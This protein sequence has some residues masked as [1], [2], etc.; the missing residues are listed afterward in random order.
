[1]AL[2][3]LKPRCFF[4]SPAPLPI[5]KSPTPRFPRIPFKNPLTLRSK[6]QLTIPVSL[7]K[8]PLRTSVIEEEE[9]VPDHQERLNSDFLS[10]AFPSLAFS[11]TLFFS[12]AYNVQLIPGDNE[13]EE[14]LI[15]RFRREVWKAGVVQECKRRRFFESTQEKRKRKTREAAKRNR[16]RLVR[17]RLIIGRIMHWQSDLNVWMLFLTLSAS[18]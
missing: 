13:P 16:K 5:P 15:R 9:A 8:L 10:V 17:V 7:Q 2:S 18:S 3:K 11:N 1:M 14:Q 4:P 6:I 12:S